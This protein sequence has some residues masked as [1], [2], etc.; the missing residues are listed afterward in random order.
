VYGFRARLGFILAPGNSILENEIWEMLPYG[1]SA[2]FTRMPLDRVTV[3][4]Y[5]N[6]TTEI[7]QYSKVFVPTQ[8]KCIGVAN[9]MAS[10]ALGK[11]GDFALVRRVQASTGVRCTTATLA[12]VSALRKLR[13]RKIGVVLPYDDQRFDKLMIGYFRA[14]QILVKAK[15]KLS[16]RGEQL[17]EDVSRQ[18]PIVSY[19]LGMKLPIKDLDAIVCPNTNLRSVEIIESLEIDSGKP[20][21]TGN[22]SL[23]WA[24]LRLAGIKDNINGKGKL[25]KL[26]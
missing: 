25:F 13:A 21:V 22:Q 15:Q 7:D 3:N 17:W 6:W 1:V 8:V 9:A 26:G 2:H 11:K 18:E 14:Y 23:V 20:V 24:S 16:I 10:F 19:E 4:D 5:S 12:I